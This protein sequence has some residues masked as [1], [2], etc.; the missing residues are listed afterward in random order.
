MCIRDRYRDL[1]CEVHRPEYQMRLRWEVGSLV[2]WDNRCVQHY[3]VYDYYERRR[4]ERVTLDGDRP[5][6]IWLVKNG[7]QK[8]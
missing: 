3:P 4:V 8:Q 1:L 7:R 5:D 6:G 2:M